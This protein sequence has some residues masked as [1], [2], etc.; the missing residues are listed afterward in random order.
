[1]KTLIQPLLYIAK[2]I[3][4]QQPIRLATKKNGDW[5]WQLAIEK[6]GNWKHKLTIE[7]NGNENG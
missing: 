1:M 7:K 3:V 4:V 5:K 6:N 2:G